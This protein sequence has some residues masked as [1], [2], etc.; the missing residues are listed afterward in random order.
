MGSEIIELRHAQIVIENIPRFPEVTGTR[1]AAVTAVVKRG[2]IRRQIERK[3]VM[4]GMHVRQIFRIGGT[5][6]W[7]PHANL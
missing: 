3:D 5:A 6:W 7:N 1:D 4:V 2:R